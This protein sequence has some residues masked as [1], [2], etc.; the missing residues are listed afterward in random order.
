MFRSPEVNAD[1]FP[2]KWVASEF[3]ARMSYFASTTYA[4]VSGRLSIRCRMPGLTSL[5]GLSVGGGLSPVS[6]NR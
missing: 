4:G 2:M 3:H 6:R 1:R 5:D